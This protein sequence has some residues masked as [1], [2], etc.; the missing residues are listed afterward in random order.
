MC[1][2]IGQR[3]DGSQEAQK[4]SQNYVERYSALWEMILRTNHQIIGEQ[5]SFFN[6]LRMCH[7]ELDEYEFEW[8]Y[9]DKT[10][11]ISKFRR[12]TE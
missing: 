2:K 6:Q 7:P 5:E 11:T 10:F 3:I 12:Q 9:K 1:F 4:L 8:N